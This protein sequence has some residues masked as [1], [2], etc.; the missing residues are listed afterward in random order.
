M[1]VVR[2]TPNERR[3]SLLKFPRHHPLPVPRFRGNFSRPSARSPIFPR[4]FALLAFP[5]ARTRELACGSADMLAP[6]PTG[7]ADLP[8][9]AFT[10]A[11]ILL[12]H[13]TSTTRARRGHF[14]RL[15]NNLPAR[16]FF[17]ARKS[18]I[19]EGTQLRCPLV[20][21]TGAVHALEDRTEPPKS[22]SRVT[23]QF[24]LVSA[25]RVEC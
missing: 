23:V 16:A 14:A 15:L 3:G 22:D 2:W 4:T 20:N 8:E 17:R 11:R 18:G 21:R 10:P 12:P 9:R 25:L 13:V 19:K 7:P 1:D 24:A 6:P 5:H